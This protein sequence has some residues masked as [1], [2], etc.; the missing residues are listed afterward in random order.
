MF[1]VD[2]FRSFLP[3]RN[4]I[5]FGAADFIELF[6]T[7]VLV[8]LTLLV[9]G[10][11]EAG[12]R[13]F[14]ERTVPCMMLLACLPIALRLVLLAYH[15]VPGPEVSDDSAICCQPIRCG[16]SGLPT[17]Y[18]QCIA[19]LRLSSFCRSRVTVLSIRWGKVSL[20]RLAGCC[21]GTHGR[22][23]CFRSVH[24]AP[25]AIGC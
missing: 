13:R 15:P 20:S 2:I 4:P 17:R 24:C 18:I 6:L 19:S 9:R 16:I 7:L 1:V 23:F 22:A 8:G 14:A 21:W 3:S 12:F 11:L 25:C 10:R 5:G